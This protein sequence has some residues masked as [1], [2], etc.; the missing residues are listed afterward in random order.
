MFVQDML[1]V[2]IDIENMNRI[3]NIKSNFQSKNK[4]FFLSHLNLLTFK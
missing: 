2:P 3:K 1:K 4:N